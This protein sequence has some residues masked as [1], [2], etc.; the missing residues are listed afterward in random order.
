MTTARLRSA[1]PRTHVRLRCVRGGA[2]IGV[3]MTSRL[4]L[5]LLLLLSAL[6]LALA[7]PVLAGDDDDDDDEDAISR[8]GVCTASSSARLEL[9]TD[10]RSGSNRGKGGD[11]E[12]DDTIRVTFTVVSKQSGVRWR[13]LLLHER[14]IVQRRTLQTRPPK[15]TFVLRSTVADWYGSEVVSARATSPGGEVCRAT[16]RL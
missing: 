2:T 10:D 7:S 3:T 4:R 13:V 15:G 11:E 8:A 6:A 14:R 1:G 5:A 9:R 16:A 12:Y